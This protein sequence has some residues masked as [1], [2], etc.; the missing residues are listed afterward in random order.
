LADYIS[1]N[2]ISSKG[3]EIEDFFNEHKEEILKL[4]KDA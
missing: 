1:S 4:Y 2:S 3:R